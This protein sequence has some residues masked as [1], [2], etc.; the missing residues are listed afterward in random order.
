MGQN[1]YG[2][3]TPNGFNISTG[4]IKTSNDYYWN[5]WGTKAL[6]GSSVTGGAD[7][8][9]STGNG[10]K[11][12]Y[13]QISGWISSAFSGVANIITAVATGK[14][15]KQ[16]NYYSQYNQGQYNSY[17]SSTTVIFL[18]AGIVALVVLLKKK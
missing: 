13:S 3:K 11:F 12:D 7:T 10:V 15:I 17:N 9:T 16:G 14:A 4:G 18:T 8:A 6:T 2:V 1:I 5:S